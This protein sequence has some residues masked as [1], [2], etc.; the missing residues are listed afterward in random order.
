MKD[1]NKKF[2]MEMKRQFKK[3]LENVPRDIDLVFENAIKDIK[4]MEGENMKNK[5]SIKRK[6]ILAASIM[7]IVVLSMQTS[8]AKEV[9]NKIMNSL[10]LSNITIFNSED[11]E[12][13]ERSLEGLEVF[14]EY[15]KRVNKMNADNKDNL[16]N[17]EGE[18]VYGIQEDGTLITAEVQKRNLE[19]N[20]KQHPVDDIII[21]DINNIYGYTCFDIKLPAYL[22][23]NY[24]FDYA[25]FY[26]DD[27]GEI[28]DKGCSVYYINKENSDSIYISQTFIYDESYSETSFKNPENIDI[29]GV[30]AIVGEEGIVWENEGVRYLM[31]TNLGLDQNIKIM[32]SIK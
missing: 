28:F 3:E 9:V 32:K 27:D 21:D 10:N 29:D 11:A 20:Q 4:N 30:N 15:G 26:K 6:G 8:F 22:P 12:I 7:C 25:E 18:K 13:E 19:E 2:D 5:T 24:E 17:K 16:Y 23:L 14:D 1:D 31:F